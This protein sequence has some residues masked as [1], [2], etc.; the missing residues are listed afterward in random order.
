[1]LTVRTRR[2]IS[3]V[4]F[5]VLVL[6]SAVVWLM[7]TDVDPMKDGVYS[8]IAKG[9]GGDVIVDVTISEG[10]IDQVEVRPHEE[11]PFIADAAIEKLTASIVEMQSADVEVISGATVTSKA[12]IAAAQQALEKAAG[13]YPDGVHSGSAKG[14]GG[15]L[16]VDVTITDGEITQ[17]DVRPH[18][19]TPFIADAAIEEL[20][21]N[22]VAMQSTEI[23]TISGA[24]VTSTALLQA[25]ENALTGTGVVEVAEEVEEEVVSETATAA[26]STLFAINVADGTHRASADGFGGELILDVTVLDGEITEIEVIESSET[27]FIANNALEKLLPAIIE[28]QGKVDTISGA[29]VT[30]KA[31]LAAVEE[32]VSGGVEPGELFAINVA[33]GTHRASADG[34]GG[35]LILDVTVLE[36]KITE[37][38]VIESSE[39]PF[40]ANNALEKL[41]PAIIAAQGKVDTISGATVT[42]KAVLAAVEHAVSGDVQI[43]VE[44][45]VEEVVGIVP[46][47]I[48]VADGTHR[49]SADGFGGELV[50]DVTVLEG[51]ITE[52]E[53]VENSETAFIADDAFEKLLPA[54]IEAQGKVDVISGATF[55]S[56]AVLE[57]VEQALVE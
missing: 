44:A 25:V 26:A 23:D 52:I 27:P 31:V 8:G 43:D 15:D 21:A 24:T 41:L 7:I 30:S 53:V 16:I 11:T 3:L 49:A 18:D 20:R 47:A 9:F 34:F 6:V 10:Q 2:N 51:K 42:S 22:I 46:F 56:K 50:L 57:A 12:L 4:L 28:A 36:G 40:I 39:T 45:E 14:F 35:E 38:E 32:A 37:I 19:E 33:D 1:M 54:I 5:V 48:N 17:V 13:I 29:T 55:T